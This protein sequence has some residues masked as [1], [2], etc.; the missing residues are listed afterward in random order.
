MWMS[1][2]CQL[3]LQARLLRGAR[4]SLVTQPAAQLTLV[5]ACNLPLLCSTPV[6]MSPELINSKNGKVRSRFASSMQATVG[7]AY[8]YLSR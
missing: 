3:V 7:A 5:F 1:C 4:G 6:Y 2:V 8:L